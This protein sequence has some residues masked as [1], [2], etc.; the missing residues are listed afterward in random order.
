MSR[1]WINE[2]LGWAHWD[3]KIYFHLTLTYDHFPLPDNIKFLFWDMH[4]SSAVLQMLLMHSIHIKKNWVAYLPLEIIYSFKISG[5]FIWKSQV[6]GYS[7]SW[8][9]IINIIVDNQQQSPWG[10]QINSIYSIKNMY[11]IISC[12]IVEDRE[13][14]L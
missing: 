11:L 13:P 6:V 10:L 12:R 9:P 7:K 1:S 3:F 5:L 4:C 14:I 2:E 8:G